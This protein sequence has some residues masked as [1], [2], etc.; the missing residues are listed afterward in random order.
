MASSYT[1]GW[2]VYY[3]LEERIWRYADTHK[4]V[5]RTHPRPCA[6]CG[7]LP[8]PEGYD[9]CMG[10]IEGAIG[11]CCGHGIQEPIICYRKNSRQ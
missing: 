5:D 9:A 7:R 6:Y 2:L 8:T 3:D 10:K 4:P 11:A 1:R